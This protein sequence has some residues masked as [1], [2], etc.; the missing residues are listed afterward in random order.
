MRANS[1]ATVPQQESFGAQRALARCV[2][3]GA[4]EAEFEALLFTAARLA[5]RDAGQPYDAA[6]RCEAIMN[7]DR[8]KG[9]T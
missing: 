2:V 7:F 8:G 6:E 5:R 1:M 3:G 9:I 4:L